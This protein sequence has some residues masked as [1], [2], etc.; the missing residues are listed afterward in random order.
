MLTA[1][2]CG[3]HGQAE[4]CLMPGQ[5]VWATLCAWLDRPAPLWGW[6]RALRWWVWSALSRKTEHSCICT[7]FKLKAVD[8]DHPEGPKDLSEV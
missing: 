5:V 2:P 1:Q 8:F 3:H 7:H 4:P 6:D